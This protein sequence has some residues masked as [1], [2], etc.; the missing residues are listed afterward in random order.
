MQAVPAGPTI[1][2]L[3]MGDNLDAILAA[4]RRNSE[5]HRLVVMDGLFDRP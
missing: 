5:E 2:R 3:V 4:G 1:P